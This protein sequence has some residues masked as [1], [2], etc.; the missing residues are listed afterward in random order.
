MNP[1]SGKGR[2]EERRGKIIILKLIVMIFVH[3]LKECENFSHLK[4]S[5][6]CTVLGNTS[7]QI[8]SVMEQYMNKTCVQ[9]IDVTGNTTSVKTYLHIK[10]LSGLVYFYSLIVIIFIIIFFFFGNTPIYMYTDNC[11]HPCDKGVTGQTLMIYQVLFHCMF[12]P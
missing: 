3:F 8:E 7:A 2:G 1:R 5:T 4:F 6:M 11:I 9:F 12:T 10:K